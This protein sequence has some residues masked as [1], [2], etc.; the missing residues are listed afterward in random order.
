MQAITLAAPPQARRSR[1]WYHPG[2][3]YRR[4]IERTSD[5]PDTQIPIEDHLEMKLLAIIYPENTQLV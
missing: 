2:E 3:Y 5:E 1:E 4:E